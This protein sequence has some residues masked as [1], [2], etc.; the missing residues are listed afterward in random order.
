MRVRK[1]SYTGRSLRSRAS[2]AVSAGV[3]AARVE[4]ALRFPPSRQLGAQIELHTDVV[5]PSQQQ[6][7]RVV[8]G[9]HVSR[10][11][12]GHLLHFALWH[13][14]HTSGP[15]CARVTRQQVAMARVDTQHAAAHRLCG[16]KRH[17]DTRLERDERLFQPLTPA[18]LRGSGRRV[19]APLLSASHIIAVSVQELERKCRWRP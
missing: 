14:Q 18:G 13:A 15:V 3:R 11:R 9:V 16:G 8:E 1:S 17:F 12:E 6:D 10:Q 19:G 4:T 2:G 7:R 5:A